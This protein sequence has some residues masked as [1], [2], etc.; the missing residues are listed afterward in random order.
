MKR[1]KQKA[2]PLMIAEYHAEALRL[3]GNVSASQ[4]R[5]FKVAATYGK[6]LEP[7]GLLAGARA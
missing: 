5:F 4:H 2:K 3:A 7:D 6:E 1:K